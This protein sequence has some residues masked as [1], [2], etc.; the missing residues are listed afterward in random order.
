MPLAPLPLNQGP[1]SLAFR[2]IEKV[3]KA[4]PVLGRVVKTWRT[5]EGKSGEDKL[6][7]SPG[8]CPYIRLTPFTGSDDRV[9]S[10]GSGMTLTESPIYLHVTTAVEG[11]RWDDSANLWDA[12][13]A[14]LFPQDFNARPAFEAVLNAAGIN[15][16]E[17]LQPGHAANLEGE[18][19][20]VAEGVLKINMLIGT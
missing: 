19:V 1:R 20:N 12:I 16:I 7:E 6:P 4:D 8:L 14:A 11:T 10:R 17:V 13:E 5:W 15:D 2:T 9:A 3:L 18:S